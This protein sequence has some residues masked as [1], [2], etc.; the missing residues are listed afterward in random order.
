MVVPHKSDWC[1][2][3]IPEKKYTFKGND[4]K[5]EKPS[6]GSVIDF[7]PCAGIS[8]E[9]FPKNLAEKEMVRAA[10]FIIIDVNIFVFICMEVFALNR[11]CLEQPV[12]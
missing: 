5:E 9:S 8:A 3:R 12:C 7:R 11:K 10:I 1:V 4:G 2:N 6:M